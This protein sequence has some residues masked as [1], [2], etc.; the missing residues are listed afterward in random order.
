MA[1]QEQ[2]ANKS[3]GGGS[4]AELGAS[5][6]EKSPGRRTR[7]I[8]PAYKH[9]QANFCK[10]PGCENF[11][12]PPREGAI[13]TGR[14]Q[15]S[16]DGYV[17]VG[18]GSTD[19][20][21]NRCMKYSRIKSNRAIC[22]EMERQRGDEDAFVLCCSNPDCAN[23][24][25]DGRTLTDRFR[26]YGTRASGTTRWMCRLCRKTV[27]VGRPTQRQ[28]KPHKNIQAFELLVNKMPINRMCEVLDV[29]FSTLYGKIDFIYAQ[30]RLFA[31]ER[32]RHLPEMAFDR[33]YLS[34]DRQDYIVNWGDRSARKTIQLTAIATADQESGYLF[35]FSPNF[36]A[37]ISPKALEEACRQADDWQLPPAMRQHARLWTQAD[38]ERSALK[39]SL[40]EAE[41]TR[42]DLD[43]P[44]HL[45]E[46]QQ[47]PPSGCQVHADYLMHGHYW[48]LRS[49]FPKAEKLR[50]FIDRDSGLLNACMGA[51]AERVKERTVDIVVV[52]IEKQL[53]T[54]VRN[55]RY[56]AA[57]AWFERE[58]LRFPGLGPKK[59][60][61]AIL[62]ERI[63]EARSGPRAPGQLHSV[64]LDYPFPTLAE[65]GKRLRYVTDLG[66][67]DDH[68]LA[69]LLIRA[70]LSPVDTAFNQVRRRFTMFERGVTSVNRAGST[71]HIYAPYNPAMVEKLL[72]IYR[73]WHNYVGPRGTQQ[74]PA[75][76][77]GLA[78]G[79]IRLQDILYFD[80]RQ[81]LV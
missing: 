55:S 9:I 68:H 76:K 30:C 35:G 80:V 52:D 73:V 24:R 46:D 16:A 79:R 49:L 59:A 64:W 40:K 4:S 23:H 13:L 71:W 21:C 20:R 37:G 78:K 29:S 56:A 8:P 39:R 50:L 18:V 38:Y 72:T 6:P 7:P 54:T 81:Y 28:R 65:P 27:S 2:S 17:I 43:A 19:L 47:L 31:Q 53:K 74:T 57:K 48:L 63:A 45:L 26:R 12:V 41:T 1:E 69:N 61:T 77:L 25:P 42:G 5:A 66:D 75:E 44:E 33:L 60:Q 22:E 10:T 62:A 67:Y 15:K 3:E 70:T 36:D 14:G 11:G 58:C 34:T 32:E 51:F